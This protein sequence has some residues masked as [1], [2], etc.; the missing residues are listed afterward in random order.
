[1]E[2]S[3][4]RGTANDDIEVQLAIGRR[5]WCEC[6]GMRIC[7][8]DVEERSASSSRN[9]QVE[10]LG[11]ANGETP[12]LAGSPSSYVHVN[13]GVGNRGGGGGD[14][15]GRRLV[16]Q[17]P[18]RHKKTYVELE[19]A[20]ATKGRFLPL[21]QRTVAN[22]SFDAGTGCSSLASGEAGRLR[23]LPTSCLTQTTKFTIIGNAHNEVANQGPRRIGSIFEPC[24]QT[25]RRWVPG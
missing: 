3:K 19:V 11:R 5:L 16:Y 13:L 10:G 17:W 2:T 12:S 15:N 9:N 7:T 8:G 21:H 22:P 4:A 20:R 1:M 6:A 14:A 18:E 23:D 25:G 24:N